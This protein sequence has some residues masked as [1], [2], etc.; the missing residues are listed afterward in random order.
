MKR[1][2]IVGSEQGAG[3]GHAPVLRID[4]GTAPGA[5]SERPHEVE[6]AEATEPRQ[7]VDGWR[8]SCRLDPLDHASKM[9][10]RQPAIAATALSS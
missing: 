8:C 1:A 7:L 6:A 5:G 2:A 4:G 3:T 9:A 10:W